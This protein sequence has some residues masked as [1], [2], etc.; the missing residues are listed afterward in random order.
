MLRLTGEW[1]FDDGILI[2]ASISALVFY[3]L[4]RDFRHVLSGK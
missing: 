3:G 2:A 4:G 1:R